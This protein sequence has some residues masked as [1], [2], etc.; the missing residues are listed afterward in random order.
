M[1]VH[2]GAAFLLR[3][4]GRSYCPTALTCRKNPR[5]QK[6]SRSLSGRSDRQGQ[7]QFGSCTS[8]EKRQGTRTSASSVSGS[9]KSQSQASLRQLGAPLRAYNRAQTA[10]PYL[11]QVLSSLTVYLLGDLLSQY[12]EYEQRPSTE[13]PSC[14]EKQQNLAGQ[15]T[16]FW[17]DSYSAHRSLRA[18]LI[19]GTFSLPSYHWFLFLSHTTMLPTHPVFSLISK[20]LINQ[21]IFTTVFQLYFFSMH[22]VLSGSSPVERV[23]ECMPTA[24]TNSWKFWPIVSSINFTLIQPRSRS[25]FGGVVAVGWQAYLGIVNGRAGKKTPAEEKFVGS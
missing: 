12:I 13:P 3:S 4:R 23:K 19:G 10:R 25:V 2:Q 18:L 20:I 21:L 9:I 8:E 24:W 11:T 7:A 17:S 15:Q 6:L 16:S 5:T 1:Q 22:A 14:N